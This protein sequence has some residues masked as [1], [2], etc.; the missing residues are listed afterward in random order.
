MWYREV[1]ETN[2]VSEMLSIELGKNSIGMFQVRLSDNIGG[3]RLAGGKYDGGGSV[4]L[5]EGLTERDAQEIRRY[6]DKYFPNPSQAA[7]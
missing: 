1:S 2:G 5:K 3:Y 7:Q 4:L 6:L